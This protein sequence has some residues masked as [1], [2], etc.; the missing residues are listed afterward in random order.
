MRHP[1]TLRSHGRHRL[2]GHTWLAWQIA[3]GAVLAEASWPLF[4]LLQF[5]Q[6]DL[7][8]RWAAEIGHF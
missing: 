7:T 1:D 2:L 5:R 4:L 6:G 8:S 3:S